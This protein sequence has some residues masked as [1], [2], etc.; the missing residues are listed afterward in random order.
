VELLTRFCAAALGLCLLVGCAGPP[1]PPSASVTAQV[2]TAALAL[3]TAAP[4]TAMLAP[5]VAPTLTATVEPSPLPS[6]IPTA[7]VEPVI[8]LAAVG[9]IMLGRSIGDVLRSDS[10]STPFAGIVEQ[11]RAPDIT[12]GN[13]EC[14]LGT[15]GQPAA[16]GFTF[17]GP[18]SGAAVLA[19]AGFDIVALANNHSL[20]FG[21]RALDETMRLLDAAG[22]GHTGVGRDAAAAHRPALITA[23][24]LRLA[25][26]A[27]VNVPIERGGFDTADWEA[28]G[29]QPGLAW[30]RPEDI[31]ADVAAARP[32]ADLV[33][34]L[35]HSGLEG[36][37]TP[38]EAQRA[39][40]YAAINAGAALV[41]GAHPHV[42]Q[43]AERYHGGLIAYSL[44]NIVF[45]G[46]WGD[47]IESAI[48]RVTLTREGVRDVA[49]TP[50]ILHGGYPHLAEGAQAGA[51]IA[52][53]EQM[54]ARLPP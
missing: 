47:E 37:Q 52:R 24:G 21:P 32:L 48:L 7:T 41:I 39:A 35:L 40:A 1:S 42:L 22:I 13:L 30:A 8:T 38:D 17:L 43:G 10:G 6:A 27:Y 2:P 31:A 4:A 36:Q 51:I 19:D 34:V 25:F 44:G 33:I 15:D 28:T 16:K 46:L 12:V 23:N 26:L 11:L 3:R 53:I 18:P 45:D 9:D 54:S 29:D 14:A 49:W 50:V 20:D 5:R